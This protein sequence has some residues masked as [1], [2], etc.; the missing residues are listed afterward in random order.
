ME[1]FFLSLSRTGGLSMWFA[2]LLLLA[3]LPGLC[4]GLLSLIFIKDNDNLK[5]LC[6][7]LELQNSSWSM[8]EMHNIT[9]YQHT[10]NINNVPVLI[11]FGF[12]ENL[13]ICQYRS[14]NYLHLSE[15]AFD[16]ALEYTTTLKQKPD[17]VD[18]NDYTVFNNKQATIFSDVIHRNLNQLYLSV[19]TFFILVQSG[20]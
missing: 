1:Q 13:N 16:V 19:T 20:L 12:S 4:I 18:C 15:L 6:T 3:N 14:Y 9:R 8:D 5:V 2:F 17:F 11:H 10:S 7:V